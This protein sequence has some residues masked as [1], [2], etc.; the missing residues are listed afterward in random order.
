MSF[1]YSKQFIV[2]TRVSYSRQEQRGDKR[3]LKEKSESHQNPLFKLFE[4][5]VLDGPQL[6]SLIKAQ[7]SLKNNF[8]V[9]GYFER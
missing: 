6:L 3:Y 4:F 1:D 7:N 2:A 8:Q 9:N 5:W